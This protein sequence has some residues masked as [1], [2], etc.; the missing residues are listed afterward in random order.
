MYAPL[1]VF[2]LVLNLSTLL[3]FSPLLLGVIV[4]RSLSEKSIFTLIGLTTT[5]GLTFNLLSHLTQVL[6]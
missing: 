2:G 1:E 5:L 3:T 4:N 6:T